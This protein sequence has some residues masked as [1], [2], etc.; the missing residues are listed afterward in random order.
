[1]NSLVTGKSGFIGRSLCEVLAEG[2]H[3]V[4]TANT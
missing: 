2:G 4:I 3:R 1:M